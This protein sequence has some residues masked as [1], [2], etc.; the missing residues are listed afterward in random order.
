[1]NYGQQILGHEVETE[2][3]WGQIQHI[4][5]QI[6]PPT[7]P[8]RDFVVTDFGA[9]GNGIMDCTDAFRRVMMAANMA[10]G[11]RVVVPAGIYLTGPIHFKSKVNLYVSKEA[12]IK[13][14]QDLEKYLPMVLNRFE[15]VELYNYSPLIYSY[16]AVNIAI[17]GEG[18]LDGN[19]D[20]EH[21][22][23]WKGLTQYGW[24]EGQVH[25]AEDRNVLFT[26]AEQ[27]VPVEERKFGSG[28]YLRPS[29]IQ[30]YNSKN[31][32][33][34]GVTVKDSPMWQISP[35]LCE[36]ITINSV[37]IIGHGPNT[38]G[39]DPDSCKNILIKNCYF[40]NGDDC[41][42]IKSGRNG[43]GRR[44]NIPCEN[45]VIQNNYMKD[46]HGG[47]TIG[48]EISGSVRNVFADHNVMDSPN[49]DRALR[50]K[51]NSVRGGIIENI[52]FRNTT[53]KSIDE[54]IF[55]V[56]MD[57][58]EGDAGEYTPIVRN[59]FVENLESYGGKTGILM[60]AYERTPISNVQFTNCILHNVETPFVLKNVERLVFKNVSINGKHYDDV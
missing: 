25:Q 37:K 21:W 43:D 53:V 15:G 2:Q 41:I 16:G 45:I 13:F 58:E 47:I 59:I 51:T 34:E 38:D 1:M 28:H 3:G 18:I 5:S 36:N 44:I 42:A 20:N 12:T 26:M 14:S 31:I 11:G 35:V 9:V 57:Y 19:G 39:F 24:Q 30:F 17:T 52:Y 56:D 10:G 27:N 32:L 49:L 46:G 40:D 55:I 54:E 6:I 60:S 48:S 23:P 29:F 4:L 8:R 50:F 33:I 22:W 7:F